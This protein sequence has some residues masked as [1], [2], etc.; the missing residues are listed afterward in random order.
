MSSHQRTRQLAIG[1][2]TGLVWLMASCDGH[3]NPPG[4]LAN[5]PGPG[6]TGKVPVRL[7]Q[8][9]PGSLRV[10]IEQARLPRSVHA[11]ADADAHSAILFRL[12]HP[13]RLRRDL[14]VAATPSSGAYQAT[15]TGLPADSSGGYTLT[16]T[17][18]RGIASASVLTDPGYQ[19]PDNLV[20]LGSATTSIAIGEAL[21]AGMSGVEI[22]TGVNLTGNPLGRLLEVETMP[23]TGS[24]VVASSSL[25]VSS[26]PSSPGTATLSLAVP[27]TTQSSGSFRTRVRLS[28]A[29][30]PLSVRTSA[31]RT[32]PLTLTGASPGSAV[33]GSVVVL[34]GT[35]FSPVSSENTV[36]VA[37]VPAVI[38]AA[39][40]TSLTLTVPVGAQTGTIQV[41]FAGVSAT[42]SFAVPT[43]RPSPTPRPTPTPTPTPRPTP[44]ATPR[45]TPPP[46]PFDPDF[47]L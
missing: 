6:E 37:G 46:T 19:A 27:A 25:T 10:R 7:F 9:H 44:T 4:L 35:G 47:L 32:F 30:G 2:A 5:Q 15:F 17:L 23:Q 34:S 45:W 18:W 41:T 21:T 13:T 40:S 14:V 1:A 38:S 20:G 42:R 22:D 26:W 12:S 16:A 33:P 29:S 39:S 43:P 36:T 31:L 3:G 8:E 28:G 11:F 24:T